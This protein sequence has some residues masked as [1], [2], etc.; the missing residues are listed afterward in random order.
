MLQV[1][2]VAFVDFTVDCLLDPNDLVDQPKDQK[3]LEAFG[4]AGA[5]ELT[6][7]HVA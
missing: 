5:C 1:V 7:N 6:C 3:C 4:L 2:A